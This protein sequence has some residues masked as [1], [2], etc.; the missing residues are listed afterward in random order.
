MKVLLRAG[1]AVDK[2]ANDGR[3][4]L[5]MAAQWGHDAVVAA[6][7]AVG[8][9]VDLPMK[10]DGR[11]ALIMAATF[12]REATVRVLLEAGADANWAAYD[13]QTPLI[14][15]MQNKHTRVMGML[16][17]A[18]ASMDKAMAGWSPGHFMTG[19]RR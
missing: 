13:G 3:T 5:L 8:A 19:R 9:D 16:V 1:A 12:G 11:T 6:I 10:G 7:V 15:A 2:A 4:S 14:M 17:E 18:G